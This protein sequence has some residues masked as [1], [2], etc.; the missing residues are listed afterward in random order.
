[1][2]ENWNDFTSSYKSVNNIIGEEYYENTENNK[3]INS[4]NERKWDINGNSGNNSQQFKNRTATNRDD[5]I[6]QE[7][8]QYNNGPSSV[9]TFK[10]YVKEINIPTNEETTKSKL[11]LQNQNNIPISKE[12]KKH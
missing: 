9:P 12:Y 1:M 6:Y 3:T 5:G 7:I 11:I 4:S 8:Q 2:A 10:E